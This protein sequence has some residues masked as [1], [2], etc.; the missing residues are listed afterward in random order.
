MHPAE[1]GWTDGS[2]KQQ[3]T[4]VC[5]LRGAHCQCKGCP[6]HCGPRV[7]AGRLAGFT[8][9]HTV[10]ASRV[11][12][13]KQGTFAWLERL[14]SLAPRPRLLFPRSLAALLKPAECCRVTTELLALIIPTH[15]V[16]P[17][18][19]GLSSSPGFASIPVPA[20]LIPSSSFQPYK[21]LDRSYLYPRPG[22][23][24]PRHAPS[25]IPTG[26]CLSESQ[27][28]SVVM[29]MDQWIREHGSAPLGQAGPQVQPCRS[30]QSCSVR[31]D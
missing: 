11:T 15:P 19:E 14:R 9:C 5:A 3:N 18:D 13:S 25:Y 8:T 17:L 31:R 6:R 21:Q 2:C 20:F 30:A 29:V 1:S 26:S 28:S 7:S 23:L 10:G 16:E 24:W 22:L 27:D 4:E 12:S